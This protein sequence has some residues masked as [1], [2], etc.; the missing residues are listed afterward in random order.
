MAGTVCVPFAGGAGVFTK[1][2]G[3]LQRKLGLSGLLVLF[4]VR[5]P[6]KWVEKQFVITL[7]WDLAAMGRPLASGYRRSW[8][9]L[10]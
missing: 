5:Y 7:R 1:E 4:A 6:I 9:P 2:N 10:L 3:P 8:T